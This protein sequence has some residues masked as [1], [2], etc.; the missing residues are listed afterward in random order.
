MRKLYL[1][2]VVIFLL[3]GACKKNADQ[4]KVDANSV[5]IAGDIYPVVKIGRQEWTTVNYNGP[6]GKNLSLP[7]PNDNYK[8]YYTVDDM[9]DL[10]L[11]AGWRVPTKDDFNKLLSNFTPQLDSVGNFVGDVNVASKL[12]SKSGWEITPDF[13]NGGTNSSGF[14]AYPAGIYVDPAHFDIWPGYYAWFL[15]STPLPAEMITFRSKYYTFIISNLFDNTS[16]DNKT[17]CYSC[18]PG[19]TENDDAAKS[20]RFVRDL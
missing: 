9:K 20:V 19:Q 10:T 5:I 11:P 7:H 18:L 12:M 1:F 4:P 13:S 2:A 17:K 16:A 3:T 6:G 15:T 14:S 8:K